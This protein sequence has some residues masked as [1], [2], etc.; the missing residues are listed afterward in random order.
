MHCELLP[1]P[2]RRRNVLADRMLL[3][4]AM[5]S[6]QLHQGHLGDVPEPQAVGGGGDL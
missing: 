2:M 3:A 4:T 5:A 1:T 6:A